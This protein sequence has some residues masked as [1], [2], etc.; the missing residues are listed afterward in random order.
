LYAA[1]AAFWVLPATC[2]ALLSGC[3]KPDTGGTKAAVAEEKKPE[4]VHHGPNG[5]LLVT[6]DT[7]NLSAMG[8]QTQALEKMELA[9]ELKAYGRV[10]DISGLALLT[11]ELTTSRAAAEASQGELARLKTLSAQNNASARS[12]QAAAAAAVKDQAQV[13]SARLRL[14]AGWGSAIAGKQDL[15]AFVQSLGALESALVEVDLPAGQPL[16]SAPT[17]ARLFTA[18]EP[19]KPVPATILG[20]AP[21]VDPLMQGRG[22]LLLVSPNPARLT[23][24]GAVTALLS[25]EGEPQR[26]VLV[27]RSAVVRHQGETFVYLETTPGTFQKVGVEVG[28]SVEAGWFAGGNVK[29]GDRIVT[30]GAQQLLSQELNTSSEE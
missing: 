24:G 29:P 7:T 8:L 19:E 18:V 21:M 14:L 17:M 16:K 30:V 28:R 22:F 27:P 10:L 2:L 11:A 3:S 9:P 12:L 6:L 5:E 25:L 20:P 23:P 26:G 15:P 1:A 4:R 13:D